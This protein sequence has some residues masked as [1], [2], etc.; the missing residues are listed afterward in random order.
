MEGIFYNAFNL[1]ANIGPVRFKSLINFFESAEDAWKKGRESDFVRI[2]IPEKVAR[3]ITKL[4]AN[5][6]PLKEFEK[7]Q[8]ENIQVIINT[9]KRYPCLLKHI[10]DPPF[11]L[12]AKG[13]ADVLKK[14]CISIVG[15]RS[16]TDYG[17]RATQMFA[18]GLA[19]NGLVIVSGLALGIDAIAH[20]STLEA[21]G[22][23]IAVLAS[24]LEDRYIFPRA[25]YKLA[26][27]IEKNGCLVSEF[28]LNTCSFKSHFPLRNRIISGISKATLVV[29]AGKRSGALI[30][31]EQ[32]LEQ[33]R[34]IYI[35]PGSIFS[36]KSEGPHRY[37]KEGAIP[38][39]SVEGILEDF[40]ITDRRNP[41][42]IQMHRAMTAEEEKVLKCIE[43]DKIH[44]DSLAK[45]SKL[46]VSTVSATLSI[47][48]IDGLVEDFGNGF[49]CLKRNS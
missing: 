26:K 43:G 38:A 27:K 19:R 46:D 1:I 45:I 36:S 20:E 24:S 48:A 10:S 33:G 40:K 12:Y 15:T 14:T 31:L 18:S 8:K 47:M 32:A 30:T 13:D 41:S 23:T 22:K 3:E 29:E 4:Q 37:L 35:V 6:D 25:N 42:P 17:K 7:V 16:N 5:T 49:Y 44:I 28:P 11:I 9:D 21:E 2:G 39:F 34:D